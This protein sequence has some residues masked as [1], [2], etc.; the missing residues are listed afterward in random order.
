MPGLLEPF[1]GS[2]E[3]RSR[4]FVGVCCDGWYAGRECVMEKEKKLFEVWSSW[5]IEAESEEEVWT[6][7][8]L[9]GFATV[10]LEQRDLEVQEVRL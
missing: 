3:G 6:L 10:G 4:V 9:F 7:L 2:R 1:L 8:N 5:E